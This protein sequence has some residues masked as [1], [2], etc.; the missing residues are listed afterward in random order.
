MKFGRR[1]TQPT[2]PTEPIHTAGLH[3]AGYMSIDASEDQLIIAAHQSLMGAPDHEFDDVIACLPTSTAPTHAP[4][5]VGYAPQLNWATWHH[6]G[7]YKT[8]WFGDSATL[9]HYAHL[10][11]TEREQLLLASRRAVSQGKTV[12][13][14]GTTVSAFIPMKPQIIITGVGLIFTSTSLP[15]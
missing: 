12:Y 5:H 10:T 13:A 15:L 2:Q 4:I 1:R 6:G 11:D 3:Y 7:E 14:V 8:Y 9:L